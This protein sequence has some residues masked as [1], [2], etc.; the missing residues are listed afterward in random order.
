[1]GPLT[2]FFITCLPKHDS[3]DAKARRS[4]ADEE[5]ILSAAKWEGSLS[6]IRPGKAGSVFV[7]VSDAFHRPLLLW[8]SSQDV[9]PGIIVAVFVFVD[10]PHVD[11]VRTGI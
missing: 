4:T 2:C 8:S 9:N 6:P 7:R 5:M 11:V 10:V 1:M 3:V